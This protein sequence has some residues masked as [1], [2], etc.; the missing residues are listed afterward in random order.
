[1][2]SE[3]NI[4]AIVDVANDHHITFLMLVEQMLKIHQYIQACASSISQR[5]A[6]MRSEFKRR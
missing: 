6:E 5:T 4:K 1:M 2:E 3:E